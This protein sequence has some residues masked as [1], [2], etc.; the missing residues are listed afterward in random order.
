MRICD[1]LRSTSGET[2]SEALVA[3]LIVSLATVLFVAMVSVSTT[4]A[5]NSQNA[6]TSV[7]GQVSTLDGSTDAASTTVTITSDPIGWNGGAVNAVLR[8]DMFSSTDDVSGR[9]ISRFVLEK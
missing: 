3:I 1:R 4:T 2:I 8:V 6:V 5:R 9:T 7:L